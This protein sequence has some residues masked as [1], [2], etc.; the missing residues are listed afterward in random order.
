MNWLLAL[1]ILCSFLCKGGEKMNYEQKKI[2]EKINRKININFRK[3]RECKHTS[4]HVYNSIILSYARYIVTNRDKKEFI[5]ELEDVQS[6]FKGL[7]L[8]NRSQSYMNTVLS[9]LRYYARK[10]YGKDS[11]ILQELENI[12]I[13]EI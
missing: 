6:F 7:A 11:K 12:R 10:T 4:R 9:A 13:S 2:L 8:N 1:I 5:M 3:F